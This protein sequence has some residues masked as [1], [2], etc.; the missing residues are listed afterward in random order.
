M[1]YTY[2]YPHPAVTVDVLI[3]TIHDNELRVLLIR[4]AMEPYEG[5]WALP[6]GFVGMHESLRRA[7]WRE[8]KEE[9]GVHAAFLE[10]LGAFGH[11]NRDPRERVITVAYYALVPHSRLEIRAAS[12]AQDARLFG[13]GFFV[14]ANGARYNR[15]VFVPPDGPVHHYDKRHLFAHGGEDER[16]DAGDDRV[17]F[18]WRGWRIC[19]SASTSL[20]MWSM[21]EK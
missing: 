9:T 5:R 21:C 20:R 8:L 7:A 4:R 12:D 18:E 19:P 10:Q 13:D 17:V 6:G 16:F 2:D 14:E 1:P 3:F 11:P 15:F